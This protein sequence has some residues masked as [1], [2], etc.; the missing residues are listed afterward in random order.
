MRKRSIKVI[1]LAEQK[2]TDLIW[3]RKHYILQ[4]MRQAGLVQVEPEIWEDS[5]KTAAMIACK[6]PTG[7]LYPPNEFEWGIMNGKL[8]AL[9]WMLGA[10]WDMLEV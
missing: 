3:F 9:R 6:Y 4:K 1:R 5:E 2:F 8:S 10:N 7:E